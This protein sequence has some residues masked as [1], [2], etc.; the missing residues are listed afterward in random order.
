MKKSRIGSSVIIMILVNLLLP[1][2]SLWEPRAQ[3]VQIMCG[4]QL[5]HNSTI[6]IQN[7]MQTM[8]NLNAQVQTSGFATAVGGSG[9]NTDHGLVQ[10]YGD[11][12]LP[13]CVLCLA[14]ARTVTPRFYPFNGAKVY[15]DGC[16]LRNE[17][18]NFFSRVY[19][20]K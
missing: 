7:F 15:L 2:A 9:L 19:W 1:D 8:K 20:T 16:F 11:L 13:E 5:P 14:Q 10:C 6:S 12:S 18:Y 3:V 17:N 4:N